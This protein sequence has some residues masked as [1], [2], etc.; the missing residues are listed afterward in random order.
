MERLCFVINLV[1]GMEREYE[2]RHAEIWPEMRAAV[3]DAG[4]TNYTLF[5]RA[6]TVVGYAEC[7]P[8]VAT[9]SAKL[10]ATEVAARWNDS[11]VS[12][13]ERLVDSEGNLQQAE[14]VWHLS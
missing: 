13:I 2:R 5:R 12:V 7:V 8:D 3:N 14:Q 6:S 11:F 1:P 9:A 4:Y 10:A